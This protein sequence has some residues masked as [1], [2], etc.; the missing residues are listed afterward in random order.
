MN[1]WEALEKSLDMCV[2][3][4]VP[5][6]LWRKRHGVS[7]TMFRRIGSCWCLCSWHSVAYAFPHIQIITTAINKSVD[8]LFHIIPGIGNSADRYFGTDGPSDWSNEEELGA[9]S[10]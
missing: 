3:E 1:G 7:T 6:E 4:E 10:Y 5:G 9:T 2:P 8:H